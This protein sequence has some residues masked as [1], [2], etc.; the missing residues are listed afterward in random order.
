MVRAL[1]SAVTTV[2]GD[3]SSTSDRPPRVRPR[4]DVAPGDRVGGRYLVEE[5]LGSGGMGVV[6][7]AR[8]ETLGHRVAIKLV[9]AA[10]SADALVRFSRE[11]RIIASLES[12]HVVRV[13]DYGVH[14]GTPYMV[15]DLLAGRDLGAELSRRGALPVE[16]AVDHVIQACEGLSVAHA[17]GIVHRDVKL[18][19]LFAA[20]RADGERIVKVLD[21]GVSKLEAPDDVQLTRTATMIGSPLYMSPEQIRDPRAVD[22]RADVWSLGIVLYKLLTNEP[23]FEGTSTNAVCAAIAADPPRPLESHGIELPSALRAVVLRCLEKRRELRYPS[24]NA[25]ARELAP[26]AS[27]RGRALAEALCQREPEPLDGAFETSTDAG[28][29][30]LDGRP[31]P[32]RA[33]RA[34]RLLAWGGVVAL[35]ATVA[36]VAKLGARSSPAAAAAERVAPA[37]SPDA[38][39]VTATSAVT[40]AA[41]VAEPPASSLPAPP[42]PD[43]AAIVSLAPAVHPARHVPSG[44]STTRRPAAAPAPHF[45]GSALDDHH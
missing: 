29:V 3:R 26:F 32:S 21:F 44:A 17:K 2:P 13:I 14:D 33:S 8:H 24:V 5:V 45:G 41:A 18:A 11:A 19:N 6:V 42:P 28:V 4:E 16:E 7:A 25:L 20:L 37:A 22:A 40:A 9:S 23:P 36:V 39:A 27:T 1:P 38:G 10:T 43:T 35:V 12:D 34:A 30:V 15:M 31:R